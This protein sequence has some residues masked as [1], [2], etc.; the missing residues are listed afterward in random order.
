[1]MQAARNRPL[2][3]ALNLPSISN[4]DLAFEELTGQIAAES[5]R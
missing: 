5:A 3:G 4:L 2:R 1:M